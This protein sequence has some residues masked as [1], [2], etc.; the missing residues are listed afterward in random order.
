MLNE[1]EEQHLTIIVILEEQKC[2]VMRHSDFLKSSLCT[3]YKERHKCFPGQNPRRS[4]TGRYTSAVASESVP[5]RGEASSFQTS[6]VPGSSLDV[7]VKAS[8]H[9]TCRGSHRA[10]PWAHPKNC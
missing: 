4:V 9:W 5:C 3:N 10:A 6:Q 2:M 1:D 8:L 7:V